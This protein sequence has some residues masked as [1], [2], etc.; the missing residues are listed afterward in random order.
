LRIAI[1]LVVSI[2]PSEKYA[3]VKLDH[4]PTNRGI[5][6]KCFKP[7]PS[8]TSKCGSPFSDADLTAHVANDNFEFQL[9][10]EPKTP[11]GTAVMPGVV[12][13]LIFMMLT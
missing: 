7:P 10:S 8:R 3:Q 13:G 9:T 2:N 12:S 4:F 11:G 5:N 1:W 6:K